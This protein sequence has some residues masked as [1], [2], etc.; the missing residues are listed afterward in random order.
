MDKFTASDMFARIRG[1]IMPIQ[2]RIDTVVID[3]PATLLAGLLILINGV[4]A[5]TVAVRATD[6]K[7]S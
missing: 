6:P 7:D 3:S 4:G 5:G 1:A 2:I